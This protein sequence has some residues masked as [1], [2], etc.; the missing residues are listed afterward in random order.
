[1][2]SCPALACESSASV[3]FLLCFSGSGDGGVGVI[4]GKGRRS[5]LLLLAVSADVAGGE[6]IHGVLL[7]RSIF[8][9]F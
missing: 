8:S 7:V 3:S 4:S 9:T 6:V 2:A 5:L 1:M